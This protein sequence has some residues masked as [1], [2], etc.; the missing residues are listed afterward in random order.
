[1]AFPI[2]TT[3][4]TANLDSP[5]DNPNLA[6]ADL[7][8]AVVAL[9]QLI[10]S[11]NAASGAVVLDGGGKIPNTLLPTSYVTSGS[12]GLNPSTGIVTLNRVLR[13]TQ[14]VTADLGTVNGTASPSAGDLI[15]LTDGDAGEPCLGCYDGTKWRIVRFMSQVGDVGAQLTSTITLTAEA[16]A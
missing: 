6:R 2:G 15:Y 12:L 4:S 7:Y 16:D 3:I 11:A 14:T 5:D 9:N 10:A 8:N 13:L 1:M